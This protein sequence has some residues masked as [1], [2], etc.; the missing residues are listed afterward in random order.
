MP[1]FS[2]DAAFPHNKT[3]SNQS[4]EEK[5]TKMKTCFSRVH[6]SIHFRLCCLCTLRHSQVQMT[7][8]AVLEFDSARWGYMAFLGPTGRL[9]A[10]GVS[11]GQG[12]RKG[13]GKVSALR[14]PKQDPRIGTDAYYTA[15]LADPTDALARATE[16]SSSFNET[17]FA[18]AAAY[19]T[20]THDYTIVGNVGSHTKFSLAQDGKVW[21]ANFSIFSPTDQ[22]P[23]VTGGQ[24]PGVLLFNPQ[25]HTSWWPETGN[26]SEYK[27]SLVGRC[28]PL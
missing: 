9:N 18:A 8:M 17:T 3:F 24:E 15:A 1:L 20:P 21:L 2:Q 16:Q 25:D 5:E 14:Q 23:N 10:S 22:G 28:V 19:L 13:V 6:S 11:G 7:P 12:F 4:I 26:F 27:T